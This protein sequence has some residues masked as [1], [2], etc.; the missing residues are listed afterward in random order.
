MKRIFFIVGAFMFLTGAPFISAAQTRP[1]TTSPT[2]PKPAVVQPTPATTAKLSDT[3]IAMVDTS[4]FGDEK[5]GIKRYLNA[6]RSV[7]SEF[8]QKQ[9]E[10]ISLQTRIKT[11]A[12]EISKL[13]AASVVSAQTIQAKQDEGERLQREFKYKKEQA[14]ADFQKRYE[15]VVGPISTDIG[16]AL[17]QYAAAHDLTMILDL[18]K[19]APAVLTMSPGMDVTLAF[20]SE[21]N[22][23]NP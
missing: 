10:L 6:V 15:T 3:R 12:D 8:Q 20:I 1:A 13:R 17:D 5:T 19:L 22:S 23:K 21:Y 4:R 7:Q 18:S 14:D 11:I 2:A 9:T 16:K